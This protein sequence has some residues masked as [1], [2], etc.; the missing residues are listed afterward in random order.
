MRDTLPSPLPALII[1]NKPR[2]CGDCEA[3]VAAFTKKLDIPIR[4]SYVR[5]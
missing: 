3:F 4:I 5:D 2:M 1:V